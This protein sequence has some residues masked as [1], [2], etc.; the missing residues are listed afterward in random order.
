MRIL[1]ANLCHRPRCLFTEA[2]AISGLSL[3]TGAGVGLL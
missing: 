1:G 3:I 2:L